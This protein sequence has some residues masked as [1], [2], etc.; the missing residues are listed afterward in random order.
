MTMTTRAKPTYEY[1]NYQHEPAHDIH[2]ITLTEPTRVAV[3]ECI[4]IMD[5]CYEG[6]TENDTIRF[7]I[8]YRQSGIPPMRYVFTAGQEWADSLEIHPNTK[9]AYVT[10]QN[11]SISMLGLLIRTLNFGHLQTRFFEEDKGY[12]DALEWIEKPF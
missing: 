6:V 10:N 7:L 11:F 1:A 4:Q 9:L 5:S 12:Q 3:D 2:I 8:D